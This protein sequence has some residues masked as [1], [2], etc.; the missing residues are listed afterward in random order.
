MM[1]MFARKITVTKGKEYVSIEKGRIS[2]VR[3]E[4]IVK[5]YSK[6]ENAKFIDVIKIRR[7]VG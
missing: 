2:V 4:K 5:M 7:G 3:K 6:T 1:T